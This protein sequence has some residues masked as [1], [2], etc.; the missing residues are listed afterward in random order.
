MTRK[1]LRSPANVKNL[2]WLIVFVRSLMNTLK[3]K[4]SRT[5]PCGT[6]KVSLKGRERVPEIRVRDCLLVK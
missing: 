3:R 2:E 6:Q 4:G 1:L 5:E